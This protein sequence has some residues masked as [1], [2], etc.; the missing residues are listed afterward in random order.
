MAEKILSKKREITRA[1]HND[2]NI[3]TLKTKRPI[4]LFQRRRFLFQTTS[5]EEQGPKSPS[6]HEPIRYRGRKRSHA[7]SP[8][9]RP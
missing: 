1:R 8:A 2:V 7:A 5:D 3:P 9:T 6:D 4:S